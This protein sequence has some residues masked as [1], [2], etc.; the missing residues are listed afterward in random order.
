MELWHTMDPLF[1]G[2]QSCRSQAR[3]GTSTPATKLIILKPSPRTPFALPKQ[4]LT[5]LDEGIPITSPE[6]WVR[7]TDQDFAHV[8]RPSPLSKESMPLFEARCRLMRETGRILVKVS[9]QRE[10]EK[11]GLSGRVEHTSVQTAGGGEVAGAEV[12]HSPFLACPQEHG[13]SFHNILQ[14]HSPGYDA[15]DIVRTVVD[16]FPAFRDESI[17]PKVG[18]VHLWKR[19]QILVAELWAAF[20]SCP[21][22]YPQIRN[23]SALTM[24]AD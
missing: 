23:V 5:A 9:R 4:T 6:Y 2:T 11:S 8:F 20:S 17:H 15:L 16:T 18:K 21:E 22:T 24:F 7:A 1:L 3:G 19:P 14:R 12:T 10:I 13:G